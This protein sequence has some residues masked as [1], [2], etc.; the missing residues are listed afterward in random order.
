VPLPPRWKWKLDQFREQMRSLFGG[1]KTSGPSLCPS[2]GT[3]VGANASR[4]HQCGTS[5]TFS[6]A[7]ASQSLGKLMPGTS[8]VTYA[9][10]SLSCLLYAV[11]LLQTLHLGGG[12]SLPGGSLFGLFNLGA[13]S[14]P[15]LARMG[16]SAPLPF[17]ISQ[18]WRLVMAIFLHGSLLHIG[19][20]MWVLLD[21]GP[22]IE[23]MY[24]S[25]RYLFLYVATGIAGYILSSLWAYVRMGSISVG[26]SGALLGLIGVLLALTTRRGGAAMRMLRS[27]LV[28]WLIY[29]A[30]LGFL[31][32]G[33]D[34][35]AHLG[36]LGA[37]FVLGKV[38][39][40]R[41]P[42][43]PQERKRAYLLGWGTAFVILASFAFMLRYYFRTH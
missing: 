7:A 39:L 6:L 8:P 35:A 40:D 15:V 25:A 14:P 11:G 36:G 34:N 33:I 2:C 9:I 26:G 41:Q 16:A 42:A 5:L 3:L 4:C 31:M 32:P 12:L 38:M 22:I 28:Q 10:L 21:V 17:D 23:E 1:Q 27:H 20:N 13:V 24:G 43:S 29:I 30:V 19:F 37:G 18:P